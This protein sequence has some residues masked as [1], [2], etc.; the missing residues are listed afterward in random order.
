MLGLILVI[1]GIL[2][3]LDRME[4]IPGGFWGYLWPVVLIVFGLHL[5]DKNK[6]GSF[7]CFGKS[8]HHKN[9]K[10]EGRKIVDEQ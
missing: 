9:S 3:L 2:L 7:C 10:R 8:K 6:S 1:V 5:I 4:L